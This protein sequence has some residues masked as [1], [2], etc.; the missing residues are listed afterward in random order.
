MQS[1]VPN[2]MVLSG[3]QITI[4]VYF[5]S[6]IDFVEINKT[7][8]PYDGSSCIPFSPNYSNP[9]VLTVV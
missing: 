3:T 8:K 2:F 7:H 5:F 1:S 6:R 9:V 4:I